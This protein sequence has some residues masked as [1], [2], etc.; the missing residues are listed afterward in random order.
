MSWKNAFI[1]GAVSTVL[2]ALACIVYA[3]IYAGALDVNFSK[4]AGIPNFIVA[5]A[6]GCLLM[7]TGYK[8]VIKWGG[9]KWMGWLN[10]LYGILSFA[11]IA[12]VFGVNLPLDIQSPELFPGM[13]VP[14]HFFPLLSVLMV[15]SF[16]QSAPQQQAV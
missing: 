7:A 1:L 12:G 10:V 4:V 9:T 5:S 14:M 2:A 6:F 8:L 13:V 15:W 16:F 11:S 3:S